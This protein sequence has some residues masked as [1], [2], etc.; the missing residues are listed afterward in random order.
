MHDRIEENLRFLII[1]VEKQLERTAA[2]LKRP[3]EAA[4]ATIVG[5]DDYIDQLEAAIQGRSGRFSRRRQASTAPARTPLVIASN[6][7][8]IGDFCEKIVLRSSRLERPEVRARYDF[9]AF[10]REAQAGVGQ[11]RQAL[12]GQDLRRAVAICGVEQRL[13]ELYLEAFTRISSDLERAPAHETQTLV[14]LLFIAHYLERMGDALLNVGEALLSAQLGEPIKLSQLEALEGSLAQAASA[15]RELGAPLTQLA[16]T[17]LGDTRSGSW[18]K[19]LSS[20][21]PA[22]RGRHS[23]SLIFKQGKTRKLARERDNVSRWQAL[24]PGLTPRIYAFH[25][26]GAHGALLFEHLPGDTFEALLLRKPWPEIAR[27]L[28]GIERQLLRVWACTRVAEPVAP[29]FLRQLSA[30]LS[31][32]LAAHPELRHGEAR[33][34]GRE[35]PSVPRLVERL[36]P[37]DEALQ[38]PFSVLIHG[39][40]NADNVLYDAARDSVGFIDLHRSALMDYV[41]DVSVF[42]VSQFRLQFLTAAIRRRI[43]ASMLRFFAFAGAF[44]ESVNDAS[45]QQRLALGLARSFATSARFVLD[46]R[47]ARSMFLRSR[48]LLERLAELYPAGRAGELTLT[49]EVLLG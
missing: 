33:I 17:G 6:L 45:F 13:D 48:Y 35:L 39:D 8:Q 32:V 20:R 1:E 9:A 18:V 15:P 22:A 25:D 40:F 5:A 49:R 11:I 47:L 4:R 26:A 12:R 10:L 31:D 29:R 27:A 19:A 34:G 7:E 43:Q 46:R 21:Q 3:T 37:Y 28:D 2:Y 44:A 23:A 42:L 30:R 41:Q 36:L 38:A 14:G 16:L 24:V